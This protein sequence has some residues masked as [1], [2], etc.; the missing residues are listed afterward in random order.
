M[1]SAAAFTFSAPLLKQ[2][3][4]KPHQ[5]SLLVAERVAEG[6]RQVLTGLA[7]QL[8]DQGKAMER[9]LDQGDNSENLE[10]YKSLGV[11]YDLVGLCEEAAEVSGKKSADPKEQL[12][13]LFWRTVE[14]LKTC[15]VFLLT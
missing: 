2:A 9:D 5:P 10:T 13:S 4:A 6:P 1:P 14:L 7:R 8:Q 11:L 3:V 12:Q 15:Q